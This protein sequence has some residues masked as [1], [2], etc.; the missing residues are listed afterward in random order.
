MTTTTATTN[1]TTTT[2][3]TDKILNA[4]MGN[5]RD[6]I[7]DIERDDVGAFLKPGQYPILVKNKFGNVIS[8]GDYEIHER[9]KHVRFE[10]GFCRIEFEYEA[11]GFDQYKH[12][13]ESPSLCNSF[14]GGQKPRFE[15]VWER[16]DQLT[17]YGEQLNE[18]IKRFIHMV[19][20]S[21]AQR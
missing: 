6:V 12:W 15:W 19:C 18:L 7:I 20:I 13:F 11:D 5:D 8:I 3:T 14:A 16:F 17:P 10:L 4:V 9:F 1:T 21:I 2:S